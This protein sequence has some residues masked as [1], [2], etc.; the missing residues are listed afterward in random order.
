VKKRDRLPTSP[1]CR[2]FDLFPLGAILCASLTLVVLLIASWIYISVKFGFDYFWQDDFIGGGAFVHQNV[3]SH[4]QNIFLYYEQPLMFDSKIQPKLIHL[5]GFSEWWNSNPEMSFSYCVVIP[6]TLQTEK[7]VNAW[8]FPP[9]I[10]ALSHPNNLLRSKFHK[11]IIKAK[12][13]SIG[14]AFSHYAFGPLRILPSFA[15]P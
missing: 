7:P 13:A 5:S 15:C 11:C 1:Q 6:G 8:F 14:S 2:C 9:E 3:C 12:T 4:L 10:K